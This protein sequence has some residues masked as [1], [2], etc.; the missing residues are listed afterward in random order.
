MILSSLSNRPARVAASCPLAL[1]V[2]LLLF[3]LAGCARNRNDP[4][5]QPP[6][7]LSPQPS[8]PASPTVTPS[9]TATPTARPTPA[10]AVTPSP[11]P[12]AHDYF[13]SPAPAACPQEAP[14]ETAAAEQPFTGGKMIWLQ[15]AAAVYVFF[16]DGQW[17][18][19]ADTWT[20]AEAESDPALTPPAGHFQP[21]RG[22]GKLWRE[23]PDLRERLGWATSVELGYT[24]AVQQP[25]SEAGEQITFLRTYNGEVYYLQELEPGRGSW[26]I[27][28]SG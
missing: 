10:P 23:N 15:N 9:G 4:T 24:A 8:A 18:R 3:L 16:P 2:M 22:F 6:V 11:T 13:F 1:L 5:P 27:A 17:Q 19:F 14:V 25:V 7:T 28:A 21:I 20:E 12:C 26:G